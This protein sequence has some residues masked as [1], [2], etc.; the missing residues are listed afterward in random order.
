MGLPRLKTETKLKQSPVPWE[1]DL[2]FLEATA[3][4]TTKVDSALRV[5]AFKTASALAG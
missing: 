2:L 4:H 5:P 3:G 1:R